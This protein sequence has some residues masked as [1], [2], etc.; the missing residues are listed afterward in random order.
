MVDLLLGPKIGLW[1][2]KH[3]DLSLVRNVIT[4]DIVI[5]EAAREQRIAVHMGNVNQLKYQSS[6]VALS[7]HYPRILREPAIARYRKVYNLHPGLL[8]WG[9]GYFPVFWALWEQ[10]P[11]GATLHEITAGIDEG[12]VIAQEDV[13]VLP[14]DTGGSLHAKVTDAEKRLFERYW[15][16]LSQGEDIPATAQRGRGTYHTKKDFVELKQNSSWQSMNANDLLRLARAMTMPGYSGLEVSLGETRFA[17][18]LIPADR[19]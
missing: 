11:A 9:K 8:P 10:T 12:P 13:E 14:D 4:L 5:A 3:A 17:L 2:L 1:V 6:E 15:S 19:N 18:E 16:Q 7:V